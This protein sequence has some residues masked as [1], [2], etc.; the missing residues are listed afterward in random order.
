MPTEERAE[1]L[2]QIAALER[3]TREQAAV[4]AELQQSAHLHTEFLLLVAHELRNPLS[5]LFTETQTRTLRLD[6]GDAAAFATD[7]LRAMFARDERQIKKMIEL[8]EEMVEYAH[9]HNGTL[10]IRLAQS[11]MTDLLGRAIATASDATGSGATGA[12]DGVT[13]GAAPHP[14]QISFQSNQ[15]ITGM[16]DAV[17]IEQILTILLTTAS[18]SGQSINVTLDATTTH[19]SITVDA[20]ATRTASAAP[21]A[22]ANLLEPGATGKLRLALHSAQRLATAMSGS[23][24][25]AVADNS[26]ENATTFT[27]TVPR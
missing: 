20:H 10:P 27:L 21:G 2:R 5:A 7:K 26:P 18:Q 22:V 25:I 14:A 9:I 6:R 3:C 16:W 23:L 13:G 24:T 15:S 19:V 4:L 1:L 8:I 11:D 17:R 12:A